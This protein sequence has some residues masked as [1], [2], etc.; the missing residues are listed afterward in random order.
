MNQIQIDEQLKQFEK[1]QIDFNNAFREFQTHQKYFS[2]SENQIRKQQLIKLL[3]N[4]DRMKTIQSEINYEYTKNLTRIQNIE[5]K[6][7]LYQTA[8]QNMNF[9]HQRDNKV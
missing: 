9:I 2:D 4:D 6:N 1:K 7:Q 3:I 5:N 8:L